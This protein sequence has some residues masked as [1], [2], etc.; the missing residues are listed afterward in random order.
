MM[1]M[2][3]SGAILTQAFG[4]AAAAAAAAERRNGSGS[5]T[6]ST[7][8]PP[9]TAPVFR[10]SRRESVSRRSMSGPLPARR[11]V[12][13]GPDARI[14]AA[15]ADVAGHGLVDVGVAGIRLVAEQRGRAHDLAR[16][17]VAA[18]RHVEGRPGR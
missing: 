16:L 14:R 2:V 5:T 15:A 17:A 3:S 12:D 1:V 11:H 9:A 10:K 4:I 13:G 8:P 18:L 6:A 7:R